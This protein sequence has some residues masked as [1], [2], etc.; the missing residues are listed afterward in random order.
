MNCMY[1]KH[2]SL[3]VLYYIICTDLHCNSLLTMSTLI[4]NIGLPFNVYNMNSVH[5]K[6]FMSF[7]F[8]AHGGQS[9]KAH[10]RVGDY[11]TSILLS[12]VF[13]CKCS[14]TFEPPVAF[15]PQSVISLWVFHWLHPYSSPDCQS[16]PS[17]RKSLV[18][19]L[20]RRKK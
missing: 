8:W 5:V 9:S 19:L 13:T 14:V 16:S 18:S 17:W 3:H 1:K 12:P 2:L 10:R 15:P 4:K 11:C 7:S 20:Q 6:C